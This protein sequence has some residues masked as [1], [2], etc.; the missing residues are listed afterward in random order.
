[1]LK[2]S[3]IQAVLAA[4]VALQ[5]LAINVQLVTVSQDDYVPGLDPFTSEGVVEIKAVI[6]K[7][8]SKEVDDTRI[9]ASDWRAFILYETTMP[10]AKP[11]DIVRITVQSANISAGDYR[12]ITCQPII[13]GDTAVMHDVQLRKL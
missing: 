10:V 4:K 6:V 11:D 7:Y 8:E 9:M 3:I 5:D 13:A 1:M 12:I 2:A